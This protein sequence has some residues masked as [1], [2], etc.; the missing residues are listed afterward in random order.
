MEQVTLKINSKIGDIAKYSDSGGSFEILQDQLE[1]LKSSISDIVSARKGVSGGLISSPIFSLLGVGS[2]LSIGARLYG[3]SY[4]E[5]ENLPSFAKELITQPLDLF[6]DQNNSFEDVANEFLKDI[7]TGE[8]SISNPFLKNPDDSGRVVVIDIAGV[9][10]YLEKTNSIISDIQN[11]FDKFYDILKKSLNSFDQSQ[12]DSKKKNYIIRNVLNTATATVMPGLFGRATPAEYFQKVTNE[13]SSKLKKINSNNISIESVLLGLRIY[14]SL[15]AL[16]SGFNSLVI[17]SQGTTSIPKAQTRAVGI[18]LEAYIPSGFI[19]GN[20]FE[21]K[22]KSY[23][24]NKSSLSDGIISFVLSEGYY[25]RLRKE[26]SKYRAK[27]FFGMAIDSG[28]ITISSKLD[29]TEALIIESAKLSLGKNNQATLSFSKSKLKRAKNYF[30][31][32]SKPN[33][34]VITIKAPASTLEVLARKE[35]SMNKKAQ[36]ATTASYYKTKS[37][38]GETMKYT[39]TDLV[40]NS[41]YLVDPKTKKKFKPKF[42]KSKPASMSGMVDKWKP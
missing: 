34:P 5:L 26:T 9:Q 28:E 23:Y 6:L 29:L 14:K 21:E 3:L 31:D 7:S 30:E 15:S 20:M 40:R 38:S 13:L 22:G 4:E 1:S 25:N 33:T 36:T 24:I 8:I 19:A 42:K 41:G 37:P 39:V 32:S 10:S 16:S 17:G 35:D 11:D 18:I 12:L 27:I 2:N